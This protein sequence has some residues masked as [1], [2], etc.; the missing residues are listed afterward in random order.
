MLAAA[1]LD[2]GCIAAIACRAR[3]RTGNTTAHPPK[4]HRY[5]GRYIHRVVE[6][7]QLLFVFSTTRVKTM[8]GV[9]LIVTW[10]PRNKV[11]RASLVFATGPWPGIRAIGSAKGHRAKNHSI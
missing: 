11:G 2:A 5:G 4:S 10:A 7:H 3:P 1:D 8:E 6:G 9:V